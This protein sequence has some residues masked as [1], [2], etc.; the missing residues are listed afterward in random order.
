[1]HITIQQASKVLGCDPVTLREMLKSDGC[2]IGMAYKAEGHTRWTY[3]IYPR[4]F[5]W[6]AGA[7]KGE[8]DEKNT[9]ADRLTDDDGGK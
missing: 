7:M 8:Q 1:M 5:E 9:N 6:F 4:A 2:P 3:V